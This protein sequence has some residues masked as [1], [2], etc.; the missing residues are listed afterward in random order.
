[1]H[2]SVQS[3]L[4]SEWRKSFLA[5]YAQLDLRSGGVNL[6]KG[7]SGRNELGDEAFPRMM[8]RTDLT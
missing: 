4:V 1:M 2:I 6:Y 7:Q 8:T 3:V 5:R